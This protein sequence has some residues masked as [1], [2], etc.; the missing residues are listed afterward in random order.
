MTRGC[1]RHYQRGCAAKPRYATL[2]AAE[3]K[4]Q[5]QWEQYGQVLYTYRCAYAAHWHLTTQKQR[6][7]A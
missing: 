6:H 5:H 4:A 1:T 3:A 7:T 2:A